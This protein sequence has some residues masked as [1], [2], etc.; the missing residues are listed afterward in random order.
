MPYK[1]VYQ[2][3]VGG[4]ARMNERCYILSFLYFIL[5]YVLTYRELYFEFGA[6]KITVYDI[7]VLFFGGVIAIQN[8][9]SE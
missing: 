7:S 5:L 8:V 1:I 2:Q 9:R 6:P 3:N 4:C